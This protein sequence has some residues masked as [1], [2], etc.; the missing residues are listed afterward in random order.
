MMKFPNF[1]YF[2][3]SR[4]RWFGVTSQVTLAPRL[5]FFALVTSARPFFEER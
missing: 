1:L 5:I 3:E 4:K 2:E